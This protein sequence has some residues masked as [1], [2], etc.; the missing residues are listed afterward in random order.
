MTAHG[1][2]VEEAEAAVAGLRE[3]VE[4][5]AH[6]SN[7]RHDPSVTELLEQAYMNVHLASDELGQG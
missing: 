4:F 1:V 3:N 7:Y 2:P 5:G 6:N